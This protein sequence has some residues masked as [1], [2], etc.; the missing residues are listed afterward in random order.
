[1]S[2]KVYDLYGTTIVELNEAKIVVE[3]VLGLELKAHESGYHCGEYFR[4]N[5]VGEEH[6]IL[7]RNFD[8]FEN[9]WTE[10]SF[11]QYLILLYVNETER[12]DKIRAL[13]EQSNNFVLLEHELA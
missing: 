8:D 4:L 7:Q 3:T 5:D 10:E 12:S 13:L 9:E 6:F 1:M 11:S 2:L